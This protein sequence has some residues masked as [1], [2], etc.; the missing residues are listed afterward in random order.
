MLENV[1]EFKGKQVTAEDE[2]RWESCLKLH[3]ISQCKDQLNEYLERFI[4]KEAMAIVDACGEHNAFDAWRQF[5]E[6]GF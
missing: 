3:D 5:A 6:R 1:E 4:V 2:T